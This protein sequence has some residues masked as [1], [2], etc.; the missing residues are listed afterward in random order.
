MHGKPFLS[1][2]RLF[3]L[4]TLLAIAW[5][6]PLP[7]AEA[8][9]KLARQRARV[10][11]LLKQNNTKEAL[12]LLKPL[13]RRNDHHGE[14]LAEDLQEACQCLASLHHEEELDALLDDTVRRHPEDWRVLAAAGKATFSA[15]HIGTIQNNAFHRGYAETL[16]SQ[17]TCYAPD[18]ARGLQYMQMAM[19]KMS[20]DAGVS[21]SVRASFF[22]DFATFFKAS[23][24][25]SLCTP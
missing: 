14:P 18:R 6:L 19:R 25:V 3:R 22:L 7:A 24:K 1:M 10:R 13:L 17:V 8:D 9:S 21:E 5:T 16:G 4:L 11:T 12:D 20:A 15:L 23:R 2:N